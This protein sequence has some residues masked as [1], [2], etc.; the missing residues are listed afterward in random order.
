MYII[1]MFYSYTNTETR[2]PAAKGQSCEN[3]LGSIRTVKNVSGKWKKINTNWNVTRPRRIMN[4]EGFP[5]PPFILQYYSGMYVK[6]HFF[7]FFF[8]TS[9]RVFYFVLYVCILYAQHVKNTQ[10]A[11]ARRQKRDGALTDRAIWNRFCCARKWTQHSR[12]RDDPWGENA[13]TNAFNH[14]NVRLIRKW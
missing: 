5:V 12:R 9:A 6:F 7:F 14:L 3:V 13:Q 8:E 11:N 10:C 1:Y 4:S 2:V